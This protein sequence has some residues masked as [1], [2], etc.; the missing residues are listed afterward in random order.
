MR[1]V[2]FIEIMTEFGDL[3]ICNQNRKNIESVF[4]SLY[5]IPILVSE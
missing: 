2:G 3:K 1:G 4:S 5:L